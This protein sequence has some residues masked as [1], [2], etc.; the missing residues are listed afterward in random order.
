VWC[1]APFD[2][3]ARLRMRTLVKHGEAGR[4]WGPSS[5]KRP[6]F[7]VR[8]LL[9]M[10]AGGSRYRRRWPRLGPRG[11]RVRGDGEG[12]PSFD[13]GLSR[14]RCLP[15]G[16]AENDLAGALPLVRFWPGAKGR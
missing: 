6:R 4:R 3:G 11:E 7:L 16:V 15:A 9:T 2:A 13:G 12:L 5:C 14:G 1:W 10:V 8:V